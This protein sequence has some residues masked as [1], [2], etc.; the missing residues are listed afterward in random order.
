M[1]E[2]SD[3]FQVMND[4]DDLCLHQVK[5]HIIVIEEMNLIIL[6]HFVCFVCFIKFC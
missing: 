3:V 5:N 2:H 4:L 6:I 1:T